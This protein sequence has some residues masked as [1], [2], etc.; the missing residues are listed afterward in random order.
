MKRQRGG[1]AIGVDVGG[2]HSCAAVIDL[3]SGKIAGSPCEVPLDSRAGAREIVT[4]LAGNIAG[5]LETSG[6]GQVSGAGLAFPGPFDYGRGISEVHGVGK[7][8]RIYGLDVSLSLFSCLQDRGVKDFRFVND[9][10][11]F[12]LGESAAGSGKGAGRMVAITLGTGVG[13]GFVADGKLVDE[14]EGIP[15]FGW[16]YC[17]PFEDGI[18]DDAFSTRWICRRYLELSGKHVQGAKEVAG[19][20]REGEFC[21]IGLFNEYGRRLAQFVSPVL[22]RFKA[23]VLVL[24]GN[25]SKA[26]GFFGP[27]L[28]KGLAEAGCRTPVRTSALFD[29]AALVGAASL[30]D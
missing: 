8:D 17:L 15:P 21:A 30:F 26:Y 25:I 16:V 4:V 28:E 9:A 23:D 5:A 3:S 24:G 1:Y 6:V 7:Y 18:A 13:S 2:S 10:S 11:A 29:R 22:A 14:G 12:A 27:A 20:C 19:R